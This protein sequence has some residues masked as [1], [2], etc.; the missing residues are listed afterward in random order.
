MLG[1]PKRTLDATGTRRARLPK[2]DW[3]QKTHVALHVQVDVARG[4]TDRRTA[5]LPRRIG[6]PAFAAPEHRT[7][8]LPGRYFAPVPMSG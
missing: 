5:Q 4:W 7:A 1:C 8:S 2:M 6:F 3:W